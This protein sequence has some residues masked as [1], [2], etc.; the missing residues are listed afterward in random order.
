MFDMQSTPQFSIPSTPRCSLATPS[1]S[2]DDV[3]IVDPVQKRKKPKQN[4]RKQKKKKSQRT[5]NKTYVYNP[6][7]WKSV[8]WDRRTCDICGDYKS[9][10]FRPVISD[11]IGKQRLIPDDLR[12]MSC[13][14]CYCRF[15]P[16]P[17]SH[18]DFGVTPRTI[19]TGT[20]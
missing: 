6:R 17:F 13:N 5:A 3:P 12:V 2:S 14:P 1:E 9:S 16:F 20:K 8:E 10:N 4:R 11:W 7:I 18:I 15:L 19:P